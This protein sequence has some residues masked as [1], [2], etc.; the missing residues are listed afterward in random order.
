M[1]RKHLHKPKTL[2]GTVALLGAMV[3]GGMASADIVRLKSVDGTINLEGELISFSD[4]YYLMQTPLGDL[5]VS[6]SRVSCEGPGCPSIGQVEA[7]VFIGGADTVA[8]GLMPLLLAGFATHTDAEAQTQSTQNSGEIATTLVGGRGFGDTIGTYMV[9]SGTSADAFNGLRDGSLQ[10]GLS[11]R[12]ITNEETRMLAAAGAGNMVDPDQE[13]IVAID[14]L[15]LV[16]NPSNPVDALSIQDVADIYT[17]RITNWSQLGGSNMP[18]EVVTQQD[19][20]TNAVFEVGIF[21]DSAA[22]I[23]SN[24]VSTSDNIAASIYVNDNPGAIAYV[25]FAFKRGQKPLTLISECGIGTTPDAFSIKTEEYSLFRRLY[26]YTS[27]NNTD[28]LVEDLVDYATSSAAGNVI[29]RSGFIGLDV[30]KVAQGA[31]GPRAQR[32]RNSGQSNLENRIVDSMLGNMAT[33]DRLSP[34]FRFAT[35]SVQLDPRGERDLE[36][37][38][39]YLQTVPNGT[40]ITFVGFADSVGAFSSNL[41]LSE[42]RADRI[43]SALLNRG[44]SALSNVTIR[45][46]GYSEIAPA[47]C[48]TSEQGRRINRRVETWVR[49]P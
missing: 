15:V 23:T 7:D 12:R 13:H 27:A 30:E 24:S 39:D 6:S 21:G 16:V 2:Y 4:D 14:G 22:P 44:G 5:R 20:G 42:G 11:S 35:G 18:I 36:R 31:N 49:L 33:M 48:N 3:L 1:K 38:V 8:T 43:R 19:S 25:G 29:L 10:V 46:T 41:A 17:G 32:I 28:P 40:E 26:M 47:A 45:S 34:T 9:N 37:L